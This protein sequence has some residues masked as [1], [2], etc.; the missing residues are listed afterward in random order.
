MLQSPVV[1]HMKLLVTYCA[2]VSQ[3]NITLTHPPSTEGAS[4]GLASLFSC[5]FIHPLSL[6]NEKIN[7]S[8]FVS[9]EPGQDD[10]GTGFH[11][12]QGRRIF[13][14]PQFP[15]GPWG[16]AASCRMGTG[17]KRPRRKAGHSTS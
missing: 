12:Q 17:V 6:I 11:S 13:S 3:I 5:S 9:R 7:G 4:F 15:Y 10:R 2:R 8:P 14:S 1:F 16:H